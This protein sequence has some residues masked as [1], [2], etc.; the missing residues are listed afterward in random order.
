VR[1]LVTAD[2]TLPVPPPLYG[3]IERIVDALV[4]GLRA[5][6][7]TV[8]LTANSDS[9]CAVDYFQAWPADVSNGLI[10]SLRNTGALLRAVSTFKPD[11]LHSFSRL[12]YLLPLLPARLAT[13]MS[14][15]RH[16]GGLRNL[17]ASML[18]GRRFVFTACSQYIAEQGRRWGGRWLAIPNFVDTDHYRF[19]PSVAADAPLVFLS[20]LERLK[21]AHL[22]IEIAH[23]S[24]RRLVIAGNRLNYGEGALYW[25]QE[26]AAHI[27]RNGIEYIGPVNDLQKI[28]LLG[29][30]AALIVPVQWD[31]PF[32]IVF[33]E[34]LACGTPV[35]SCP[36]G[37]LPEIVRE[38]E[39][40]FL[41]GTAEEGVN[42]IR[43]LQSIS[44]ATCR[45]NAEQFFSQKVVVRQYEALY[46]ELAGANS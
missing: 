2:P 41:I 19:V 33:I 11:V 38:R 6:G 24:G 21:G 23:R 42:A 26:I 36:R 34:S 4:R 22:A 20:R 7:H 39:N 40:G 43:R 45:S 3:G 31:E 14:Y 27:G 46:N 13:V 15:Q 25:E 17:V 35:I 44:R 30:A 5:R 9:T 8:G 29:S 12:G 18:G 32:G 37:A 16:T 28:E 10:A 1:I